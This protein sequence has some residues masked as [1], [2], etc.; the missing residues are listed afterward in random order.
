[1]QRLK[2]KLDLK[3]S[4]VEYQSINKNIGQYRFELHRLEDTINPFNEDSGNRYS[5]LQAEMLITKL[6]GQ[7]IQTIP[8]I[9]SLP[10]PFFEFIDL[11][12]DNYIDLLIYT[13][14]I[15]NGSISVPEAYLYI[16]KLKKFIK[17]NTISSYGVITK[18]KKHGCVTIE[19]ER[20]SSGSTVDETCFNLKTG[21]WRKIKSTRYELTE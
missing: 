13:S 21:K 14:D 2:L 18:S 4:L 6:D 10:N 20:T 5:M 7:P 3:K 9:I 12:D 11:N 16:P 15:P 17:S 19:Y 1:M 8:I